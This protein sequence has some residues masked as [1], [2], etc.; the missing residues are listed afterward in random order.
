MSTPRRTDLRR[1][2]QV[3]WEDLKPW[4]DQLYEEFHARVDISVSVLP[5]TWKLTS[6]VSVAVYTQG[7][8]A[9]R[10]ELWADW[11]PLEPT[12]YGG[13]ESAVLRMISQCLL[14]LSGD[15]ERSERQA[16]LL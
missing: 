1:N 2:T 12:V 11:K 5:E 3:A 6:A 15:R 4:I 8:R 9:E 10:R 13:V 14:E 7:L 16:T